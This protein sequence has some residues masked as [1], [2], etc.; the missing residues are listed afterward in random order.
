MWLKYNYMAVVHNCKK[1]QR[2]LGTGFCFCVWVNLLASFEFDSNL[3]R[4]IGHWSFDGCNLLACTCT[5]RREIR[6]EKHLWGPCHVVHMLCCG[7]VAQ[8]WVMHLLLLYTQCMR[9]IC[10]WTRCVA[11]GGWITFCFLANEMCV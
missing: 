11:V 9:S 1:V 7:Q 3:K 10:K 4:L 5:R 6:L 8:A 2:H